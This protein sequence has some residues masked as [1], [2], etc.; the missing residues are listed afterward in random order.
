MW[1]WNYITL[2]GFVIKLRYVVVLELNY[3]MWFWNYIKLCG[4]G[5][6]LRYAVLELN[7]VMWF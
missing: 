6:K 7:Y 1:F 3:A 2:C 4:F 5:I